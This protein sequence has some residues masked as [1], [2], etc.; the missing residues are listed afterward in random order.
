MEQGISSVLTQNDQQD[1]ETNKR[2]NSVKTYLQSILITKYVL[3]CTE[4]E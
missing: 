4:M 2:I 3:C 1:E